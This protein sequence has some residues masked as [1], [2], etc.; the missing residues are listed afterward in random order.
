MTG[1]AG[2]AL[3]GAAG[4]NRVGLWA[5]ALRCSS[6]TLTRFVQGSKAESFG[7]GGSGRKVVWFWGQLEVTDCP[8]SWALGSG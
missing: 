4:G 6:G 3:G 7:L 8:C 5:E 1:W 2:D